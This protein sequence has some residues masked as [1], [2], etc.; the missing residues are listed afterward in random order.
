MG[1]LLNVKG[2]HMFLRVINEKTV[3][4]TI[5]LL[6]EQSDNIGIRLAVEMNIN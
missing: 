2:G 5:T 1:A 3:M 4:C 6:V